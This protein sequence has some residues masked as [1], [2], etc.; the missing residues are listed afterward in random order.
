MH[1]EFRAAGKEALFQELK[2]YLTGE[3]L[4]TSYADMAVKLKT[5]EAAL[6]MAVSRMRQRYAE[7]LRAE[8][9]STVSRPED[10]DDELRALVTA[11]GR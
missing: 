10:V 6:K 11:L 9:A 4:G 5:T 8:I 1:Q 2:I 3:R 7:M